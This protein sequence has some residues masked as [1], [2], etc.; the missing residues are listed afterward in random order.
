[1]ARD[2]PQGQITPAARPVSAFVAPRRRDIAAPAQPQMLPNPQG[3]RILPQASGG[4]VGGGNRFAELASALSDFSPGLLRMAGQALEQQAAGEYQRG[5]NEAMRA[6]VLANQ[7]MLQSGAEYAAQTRRIGRADPEAGLLMDRVNPYRQAGRQNALSRLAAEEANQVALDEYRA[8]PDAA[9]LRPGDPRLAEVKARAV[10][11]LSEKYGLSPS[12]P[13]FVDYVLPALG[14]AQDRITNVH[15][16]EH[17]AYLDD[18]V[19]KTAAA[20]IIA[21][22]YNALTG[23]APDGTQG[24][25]EWTEYDP[26]SGQPRRLS[27]TAADPAAFERGVRMRAE[28]IVNALANET[29]MSGQVAKWQ[30]EVLL[31]AAGSVPDK[32]LRRILMEVGVGPVQ[33]DG[34]RTPASLAFGPEF[35]KIEEEMADRSWKNRQRAQEEAEGMASR[36]VYNVMT[37][38]QEGPQ[39]EAAVR[40]LVAAITNGEHPDVGKAGLLLDPIKVVEMANKAGKATEELAARTYDRQPFD[41]FILQMETQTGSAWNPQQ[42]LAT[43]R[44]LINTVP[45]EERPAAQRAFQEQYR[46]REAEVT[47]LPWQ[48]INRS[49]E[50]AIRANIRAKYPGSETEAALRGGNPIEQMAWGNANTA[51]SIRRQK[52]ALEAHVTASLQQAAARK[53]ARLTPAES[54]AEINRAI[55]EYG[56]RDPKQRAYLFP[57][58]GSEPSVGGARPQPPTSAEDAPKPPAGRQQFTGRVY[59][60]GQLDNAPD[61]SQ[62]LRSGDPILDGPSAMREAQRVLSGGT[63][64]AP[65]LRAAKDSGMSP[66]RFLLRQLDAYPGLRLPQGARDQLLRSSREAGALGRVA[67]QPAGSRP[68]DI[69]GRWAM[70]L[71]MGTRPAMATAIPTSDRSASPPATA[72][73]TATGSRGVEALLGLIRSGEGSWN[74]VNRGRAGDTPGGLGNLTAKSIGSIEQMQSSGRVF[75]VGAY[76]FTPGVLARARREAG[77]SPGA[78]FSPENQNRMAMALLLGSKRPALA[79]YLSGRSNNLNAAHREVALEWAALQGPGGRGMYDGTAG[80][81]GGIPAARVRQAL[82]DARQSLMG[83]NR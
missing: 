51:E 52:A 35:L 72:T 9:Q 34:S 45:R 75:A 12:T 17:R 69:A 10:Q 32:R 39:Q 82:I 14:Q 54:S 50:T 2:L 61:R 6:Q 16:D 46:R 7:Q 43:F 74:S 73:A 38:T 80:N 71:L 65:V 24:F 70:D 21:S 56:G 58:V 44:Q 49:I 66:G 67:S 33:K 59:P 64:S 76:Q 78:P 79:A 19:P 48:Q 42:A 29:G 55:Q 11:R 23:T 28:Q 15:W 63:P 57:G 26:A 1:M 77:L 13:G 8:L 20:E 83:G 31:R 22:Y 25:V 47:N 40:D 27:A 18:T 81:H 5:A 53:G 36:L 41:D 37:E 4:S 68:L 3:L 60:A 30:Q 62:R